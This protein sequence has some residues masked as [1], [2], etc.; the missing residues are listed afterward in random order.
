VPRLKRLFQNLYANRQKYGIKALIYDPI[1]QWFAGGK[2]TSQPYG[3]H[4]DHLHVGFTVSADVAMKQ[5]RRKDTLATSSPAKPKPAQKA[6]TVVLAR[7]PRTQYIPIPF[8]QP[9]PA[10]SS[11][12][13]PTP[14]ISPLWGV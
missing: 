10:R 14:S 13:A 5:E 1:G 2:F 6:T 11:I 7:Q 9:S 4:E 12:A 8:Q 3:D